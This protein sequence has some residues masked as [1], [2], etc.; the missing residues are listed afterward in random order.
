MAYRW[1]FL[2]LPLLFVACG[3]ETHGSTWHDHVG[4]ATLTSPVAPEVR[5]L[6]YPPF[7][8]GIFPCSR[9]HIGGPERVEA[10]PGPAFPH[11]PHLESDL[12]CGDCHMPEGGTDPRLPVAAICLDCHDDPASD[13]D[14]V[15]EYFAATRDD[16]GEFRY[17]RRWKTRDTKPNHPGH[18]KAGVEC[19]VCHGAPSN[20]PFVKPRPVP[21]M[22]SCVACHKEREAPV[23]CATC[24]RE[25]RDR[26]HKAIVLHHAE[27]QRGCLDCHNPDDRDTVRLANGT[28]LPFEESYLLC[29]QCHGPKLRDWRLG[30][31]GKRTGFWNGAKRYL[32]CVHCHNPHSPRYPSM[33][34]QERPK[35]PEEIR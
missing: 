2:L 15:R 27:K 30:L 20:R 34:A 17:A 8:E 21:L 13:T 10:D 1:L 32:L 9:C 33:V 6:E 5:E 19:G 7:S 26:Q 3:A 24:H 29:G 31:H 35:R 4:D 11:L 16:A 23:E 28:K 14:A 22:K 12:E 18:A 25:I